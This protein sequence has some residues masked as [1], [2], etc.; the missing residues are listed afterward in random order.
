[1]KESSKKNKLLGLFSGLVVL[2]A[3][4][5]V[6][7]KSSSVASAEDVFKNVYGNMLSQK[8]YTNTISSKTN[9]G[10]LTMTANIDSSDSANMKFDA[11]FNMVIGD[12]QSSE[13]LDMTMDMIFIDDDAYAQFSK[14]EFLGFDEGVD[15]SEFSAGL[16]KLTGKWMLFI[17]D[18]EMTII[19]QEQGADDLT[20]GLDSPLGQNV[21]GNYT[22]QQIN[23]LNSIL[24]EEQVYTIV[25]EPTEEEVNGVKTYKYKVAINEEGLKVYNQELA[26]MLNLG[27]GAYEDFLQ[28]LISSQS[29]ENYYMWVDKQSQLP[30]R[31]TFDLS[32]SGVEAETVVDYSNYNQDFNITAP[33]VDLTPEEYQ[34]LLTQ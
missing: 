16:D 26:S 10:D 30:V 6:V 11:D 27:D 21:I 31:M 25:G 1:M 20:S 32:A 4:V 3:I 12:Q 14:I 13:S 19:G 18:G 15:T 33:Q 7:V 28:E 8:S 5:F 2:A 9:F 17:E 24:E 34:Q 22:T 23:K 29:Y